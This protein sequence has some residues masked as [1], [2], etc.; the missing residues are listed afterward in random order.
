[1]PRG[2]SRTQLLR[3]TEKANLRSFGFERGEVK[4]KLYFTMVVFYLRQACEGGHR[5]KGLSRGERALCLLWRSNVP[6]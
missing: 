1:M 2:A 5:G 4:Q 6:K 3:C